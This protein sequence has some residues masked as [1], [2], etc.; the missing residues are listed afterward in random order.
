[1]RAP[2]SPTFPGRAGQ[3]VPDAAPGTAGTAVAE[4]EQ[5]PQAP[6]TGGG[7]GPQADQTTDFGDLDGRVVSLCATGDLACDAPDHAPILHAVANIAGQVQETGGDPLCALWSLTQALAMT[8]IKTVTNVVNDDVQGDSLQNLSINP[9]VSLSQRIAD[10]S[11]PRSPFD[12][13]D[14]VSAVMKVVGIGFNSVL[15]A[16]A[17]ILSPDTI[18]AVAAAGLSNPVAG[19]AVFGERLLGAL[20]QIVPPSTVIGLVQDAFQVVTSNITDNRDL[21]NVAAW[22]KYSDAINRHDSYGQDPITSNGRSATR[23]AADWFTAAAKDIAAAPAVTSTSTPS[24]RG[25][26]SSAVG[27]FDSNATTPTDTSTP[28]DPPAEENPWQPDDR[29]SGLENLPFPGVATTTARQPR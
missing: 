22:T 29:T 26:S 19:L 27:G 8:S 13:G 5:V 25:E 9:G 3:Q 18:A 2:G 15:S 4:L 14:A 23:Y 10:A 21:V 11:D 16:A 7:I 24:N 1:V 28:S 17:T 20:P 12:P 6:T